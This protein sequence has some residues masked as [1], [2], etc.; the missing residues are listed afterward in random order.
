MPDAT[1]AVWVMMRSICAPA[2]ATSTGKRQ[3]CARRGG[4]RLVSMRLRRVAAAARDHRDSATHPQFGIAAQY[5]L[6]SCAR[7]VRLTAETPG[8]ESETRRQVPTRRLWLPPSLL[9]L[10]AGDGAEWRSCVQ[11]PSSLPFFRRVGA[12]APLRLL[13]FPGLP[14]VPRLIAEDRVCPGWTMRR[15]FARG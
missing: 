9:H 12:R 8:T 4:G 13:H 2:R 14:V 3:R 7:S 10:L 15:R 5:R 11:V 6:A 1:N